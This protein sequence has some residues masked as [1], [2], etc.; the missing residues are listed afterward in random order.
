MNF[1]SDGYTASN[2]S[3]QMLVKSAYNLEDYQVAD[4]GKLLGSTKY[5]IRATID[6]DTADALNKL[7]PEQRRR[8]QQQMLQ[9]LLADRF[10]LVAHEESKEFPVYFLLLAANGPKVHESKPG[11]NYS[12]GL[13]TA[14]GALVGPHMGVSSLRGGDIT[15]QGLPINSLVQSLMREVGKPV[16][17]KTGL[18][19]IYD[20]SLHWQPAAASMEGSESNAPSVFEALEDQLGL[21]LQPAKA[22]VTML[23]ID[24]VEP[25]SPN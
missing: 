4:A 5:D 18:T 20:Y 13:K 24:H 16:V 6:R 25:V 9:N 11:D 19:G 22:P 12:N 1:E 17:D 8:A 23:V 2:V 14:N 10:K 3:L 7:E 21:K 15:V